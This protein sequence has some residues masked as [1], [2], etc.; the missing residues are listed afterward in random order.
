MPDPVNHPSHYNSHPSG[1]E[2]KTITGHAMH[3]IGAAIEYL[4]RVEWGDK[5][6]E[7]QDLRKAIRNIEFEIERRLEV[8]DG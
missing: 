3:H 5:G 2:C 8:R 1:I 6:D 7:I 4:W